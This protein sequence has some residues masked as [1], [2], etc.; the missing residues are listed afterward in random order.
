M[1]TD[2]HRLASGSSILLSLPAEIFSRR[3]RSSRARYL[4]EIIVGRLLRITSSSS[5][6]ILAS[7]TK[8]DGGILLDYH[9]HCRGTNSNTSLSLYKAARIKFTAFCE[10]TNIKEKKERE[11]ISYTVLPRI[12]RIPRMPSLGAFSLQAILMSMK[13]LVFSHF[14]NC[15]S[16]WLSSKLKFYKDSFLFN[17]KIWFQAIIKIIYFLFSGLQVHYK[18]DIF[19]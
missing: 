6:L 4:A 3:R 1:S 12:A 7:V 19:F 18:S 9:R 17:W 8:E 5:N 2:R 11:D 14:S 10:C 13:Q 15:L 16:L